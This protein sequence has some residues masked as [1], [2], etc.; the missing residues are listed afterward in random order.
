M[1][2]YLSAILVFDVLLPALLLGLP[3][4]I[5]FWALMSFQQF[6]ETK[7]A[8]FSA[9]HDRVRFVEALNRELQPVQAK[10][11]LLKTLVS[12]ND[13][14]SRVDHG[15]LS[16]LE[17]F[18]PDEIERTLHDSQYGTSTIG[19]AVG[20]G[21]RLALKFSSRW[22]PLTIAALEWET[23]CPNLLLE[24]LSIS[25]SGGLQTS[26]PYLESTFSYFVI[27]EN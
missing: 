12:S 5:L 14:E 9:H 13:I 26:A 18:S 11:P 3:G 1:K 7:T 10:V 24:T 23:S 8:E 16:A 17:K 22:E 2:K 27:T 19:Q 25:R 6:A 4:C 21:H 15:I 20:E